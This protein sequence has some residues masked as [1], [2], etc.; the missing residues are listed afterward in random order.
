VLACDLPFVHSGLLARLV[1]RHE[2]EQTLPFVACADVTAGRPEPLCAIYGP[3]AGPI[4]ARCAA[5]GKF[6]PRRIMIQEN[7]LLLDVA[8]G[9]ESALT[10]VNT[11][12]ELA[13]T[14]AEAGPR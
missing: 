12:Q 5:R 1:E 14:R 3:S 11:P 13:A 4:L 8:E 7:A 2:M 6:S 10:N 9:D